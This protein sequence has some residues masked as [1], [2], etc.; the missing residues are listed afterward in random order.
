[1]HCG[2]LAHDRF[3]GITD[4]ALKYPLKPA[5]CFLAPHPES[6]L[7]P[8]LRREL[9]LVLPIRADDDV[10]VVVPGQ[11][12]SGGIPERRGQFSHCNIRCYELDSEHVQTLAY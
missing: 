11:R 7:P 6:D 3:Q 5:S 9:G 10:G 8:R 2:V 12:N 1:M 4:Q